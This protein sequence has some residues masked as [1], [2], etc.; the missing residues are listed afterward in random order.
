MPREEF[1]MTDEQL[2]RL[3]DRCKPV[4]L[5]MLQ[6]G[7]PASPQENANTAWEELGEEMG[8]EHMTIKPAGKDQRKFTA[9]ATRLN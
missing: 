2:K 8:F 4:P 6:C 7:M 5:I 1:T 9:E 3:L